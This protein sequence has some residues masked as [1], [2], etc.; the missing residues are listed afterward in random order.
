MGVSYE[1]SRN[2]AIRMINRRFETFLASKDDFYRQRCEDAVHLYY[3]VELIGPA[4]YVRY[5][6]QLGRESKS[7]SCFGF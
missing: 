3:M 4:E 6:E 2:E 1:T 5:I 7:F